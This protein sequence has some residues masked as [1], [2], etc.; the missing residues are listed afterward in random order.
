[1]PAS[2]AS[3]SSEKPFAFSARN[4]IARFRQAVG[5]DAVLPVDD[6]L[7]LRDEPRV[8]L[9]GQIDLLVIDI[10]PQRL[11]D[12]Q[13]AVRRRAAQRLA[14]DVLVVALARD[15]RR[16]TSSRPVSSVS[17]ERSAFCSDSWKVPPRPS[18]SPT[19]FIE[20][21]SVEIGAGEFLEG[22][23]RDL[24][25]HI[26]DGRL[27]GGGRRA[28]RDVVV[29]LVERIADGEPGGDLGDREARRLR[30]QRRGAR[31]A[32][33]HL[34]DDQLAVRRIDGELHVRAARIDADLA[35]HRDRGVAHHLIFFV[36]Q[37]QRRRDG[38][39]VARMHA[40]RVDILDGADDDAVVRACRGPPPSH[41]PSSRAPIP[42]PALRASARRRGRAR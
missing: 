18:T 6:L 26:V 42:R 1:M 23:A 37:R 9:A 5:A 16:C 21:V 38:D 28:L 30:G 20:V 33:V 22:E 2:V 34:D 25:D 3:R 39:G 17:I 27:E 40:H 24:G 32:R 15:R 41:I 36:G 14:D 19:D 11:R 10:E 35:Q 13:N 8:D 4:S 29:Q 12:L 7:D 31:H